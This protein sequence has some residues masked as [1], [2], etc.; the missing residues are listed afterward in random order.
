MNDLGDLAR[1]K[2]MEPFWG[3]WTLGKMIGEGAFGKVFEIER[4]DFGR[5]Y[6]AALKIITIPQSESE[7]MSVMT[8]GMD[9][10]SVTN[11]FLGLVNETV[12][13]IVM[14]NRFK[15]NSHI[16]SYEDHKVVQHP[17]KHGWDILVRMELL[18]PFTEAM[19]QRYSMDYGSVIKVGIDMCMALETCHNNKVI[20]RDIKPEN[21]FVSPNGDFKLGDFGIAR[22]IE[23]TMGAL[24]RKGTY[25]YMAPEVYKGEAYGFTADIYSLGIVLY[26]LLNRN[27][28]PFIPTDREAITHSDREQALIRQIGGE[29]MPMPVDAQNN[30]GSVI[31][32]A[33]AFRPQDRFQSAKELRTALEQI[34][35]TGISDLTIREGISTDGRRPSIARKE[36]PSL[37]LFDNSSR[38]REKEQERLDIV[39]I[40]KNKLIIIIICLGAILI[41]V[42]SVIAYISSYYRKIDERRA[43]VFLEML[44][45]IEEDG[46]FTFDENTELMTYIYDLDKKGNKKIDELKKR[47]PE[48]YAE[49]EY[50]LANDY[51]FFS[52]EFDGRIRAGQWYEEVIN[53]EY[54]GEEKKQVTQRLYRI[55]MHNSNLRNAVYMVSNN[56]YDYYDLYNDMVY[57]TDG[58]VISKSGSVL[59]A[60]AIYDDFAETILFCELEFLSRGISRTEMTEQLDKIEAAVNTMETSEAVVRKL[61]EQTKFTIEQARRILEYSGE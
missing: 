26:R 24:S 16:V 19:L 36:K 56:N 11:Y 27:R 14:M 4:E 45:D 51:F 5:H 37:K 59:Y 33:C 39:P 52:S 15:G 9:E 3:E 41:I 49:F 2:M 50:R 12:E 53:S 6:S 34:C 42:A 61:V 35:V 40:S 60:V 8:D 38:S 46:E 25:T 48:I 30:L 44:D 21:I 29:M 1:Y 54:I 43:E 55:S 58:N 57:L 17:N 32:K 28:A 10:R 47:F 22:T 18:K 13:E 20:H 23:K 31:L 7:W